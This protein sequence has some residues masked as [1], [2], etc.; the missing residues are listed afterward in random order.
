MPEIPAAPQVTGP[1]KETQTYLRE[2]WSWPCMGTN[3]ESSEPLQRAMTSINSALPAL[4][5]KLLHRI[6]AGEYIDFGDLPPARSKPHSLP[7]YLQGHVLVLQMQELEG[8]SKRAIPDFTTWAQ[9]FALYTAAILM[10][11]PERA[12]D[13]MAYLFMIANNAWRYRWGVIIL[14]NGTECYIA[15]LSGTQQLFNISL[16]LLLL[17]LLLLQACGLHNQVVNDLGI[18]TER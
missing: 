7:H 2:L 3:S 10:R 9:C 18:L 17:S 13:L 16:L 5:T 8:N 12:P 6:W 4:P 1:Q 14:R 11:Q 15:L